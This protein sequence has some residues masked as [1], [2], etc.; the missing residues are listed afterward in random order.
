MATNSDNSIILVAIVAMAGYILWRIFGSGTTRYEM[1]QSDWTA[2]VAKGKQN[3]SDLLDS[4]PA[5]TLD[6]SALSTPLQMT[7][8]SFDLPVN[9]GS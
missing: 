1:S 9:S 2:A 6:L 4:S 3:V 8:P 7:L 5:P